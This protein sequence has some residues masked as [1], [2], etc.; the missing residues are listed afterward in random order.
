M[1]SRIGLPDPYVRYLDSRVRD[2]ER[3]LGP[4]VRAL[5]DRYVGKAA[6]HERP[7]RATADWHRAYTYYYGP[8]N[9]LK[10]QL[11]A[12][13]LARR[14]PT[15]PGKHALRI[16]D[17][18]AG[19]GSA[20]AGIHLWNPALRLDCL[21]VDADA[22]WDGTELVQPWIDAGAL[23]VRRRTQ[24][25]DD[26]CHGDFDLVLAANVVTELRMEVS[27]RAECLGRLLSRRLA[28]DGIAIIVEP[29]LRRATRDLHALRQRLLTAGWHVLAPCTGEGTCPMLSNDRDWCHETRDWIQPDFHHRLD[30]LAGLEKDA[31]RFSFLAL[32]RV[33]SPIATAPAARIVS[34]IR[35]QKGR[36]R[37]VTCDAASQVAAWEIQRRDLRASAA[38]RA[39][40]EALRRG[41]LVQLPHDR[42]GRLDPSAALRL[43]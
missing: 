32:S 34:E 6:S 19:P 22:A 20:T 26:G 14:I 12:A 30:Q 18:G 42:G 37:L 9:A 36:I 35:H 25:L 38:F 17:L 40:V 33:P 23:D 15:W 5:S 8:V 39:T 27:A 16:L 2:D 7:P 31:L 29:A 43:L 3:R 11:I 24:D 4:L 28:A 21:W 1:T 41:A 13:E 10:V